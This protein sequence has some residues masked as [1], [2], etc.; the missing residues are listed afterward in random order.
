MIVEIF[1]L[2]NLIMNLNRMTEIRMISKFLIPETAILLNWH[3]KLLPIQISYKATRMSNPIS[4]TSSVE[5]R[6]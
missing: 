2:D 5:D 1:S 6:Q 3:D 4:R